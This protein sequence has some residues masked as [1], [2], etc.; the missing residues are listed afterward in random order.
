MSVVNEEKIKDLYLNGVVKVENLFEK[1]Y[2]DK[3]ILSKKLLFDKF[4][5]GQ[6]IN[7]KKI[8]KSDYVLQGNHIIRDIIEQQPIFKEILEN[9]TI[10]NVARKVLGENFIFTDFYIRRIPQDDHVLDAHIDCRGGLSFS[11]LLDELNQNEGETFFYKKSHKYPPPPF[12]NFES[13]ELKQDLL[14]SIGKIGDVFFWFR[15]CWHG[16]NLNSKSEGTTILI[17]HI[18]NKNTISKDIN[19]V[20]KGKNIKNIDYINFSDNQKSLKNKLFNR[21]FKFLGISPNSIIKHFF[22]SIL[23]FKI[24]KITELVEKEKFIYT[25]LKFGEESIDHFSLFNYFKIVKIQKFIKVLVGDFI[26][27]L[28][29]RR[30]YAF[31]RKGFRKLK[32]SKDQS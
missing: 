24:K 25:R 31:A 27:L 23:C 30:G 2:L 15:D 14:L 12:A 16:R 21:I 18:G 11:M 20:F 17:C 26:L 1:N 8:T 13:K 6:D 7:L 10:N 9:K 32:S 29:G 28:F 22:Y 19:D 5:Y 3:V 4:P